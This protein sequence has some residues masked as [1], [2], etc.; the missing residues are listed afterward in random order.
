[1]MTAHDRALAWANVVVALGAAVVFMACWSELGAQLE[2]DPNPNVLTM[3]T[4]GLRLSLLSI[5]A[6]LFAIVTYARSY[7]RVVRATAAV[8]GGAAAAG[9]LAFDAWLMTL[10]PFE[11]VKLNMFAFMLIPVLLHGAL[12]WA[13]WPARQRG[14]A[15]LP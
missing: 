8:F 10:S 14:A 15:L 12:A 5:F 13:I 2:G 9:W 7:G 6:C 11:W 3:V 4:S 1:M